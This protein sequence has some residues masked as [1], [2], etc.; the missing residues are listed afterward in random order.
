MTTLQPTPSFA[1][2]SEVEQLQS[3]FS[4]YHKSVHGFRPRFGTDTE[5]NS[6]QWL[7][8]QVAQLDAVAPAIEAQEAAAEQ[9]AIARFEAQLQA[10]VAA[11]AG[12]RA[13]AIRWLVEA[14]G[15]DYCTFDPD[16]FCFLNGLP[17][18]YIKKG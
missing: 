8:A 3:L 10:T 14:E 16:Y 2:L 9:A 4:D 5:W 12:D 1:A 18:G 13:T 11:G 17:Y 15:D 7:E 6:I